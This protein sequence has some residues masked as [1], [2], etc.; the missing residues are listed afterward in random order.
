MFRNYFGGG[1]HGYAYDL[2]DVAE[3][4]NLY[5]DLMGF[6]QETFPNQIYNLNYEALTENQEE[7]SRRLLEYCGIDWEQQC[8]AFHKTRRSVR[9]LSSQ[10]VRKKMYAGS[11]QAWRKYEAHIQPMLALLPG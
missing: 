3:Y 6:W 4:Y 9:T 5:K 1:G 7:E 2:V 11:S 10:Q 8:L